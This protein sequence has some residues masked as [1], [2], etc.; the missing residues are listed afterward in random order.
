MKGTG[1][2]G[3]FFDPQ[4]SPFGY[5]ETKASDWYPM[6]V[7]EALSGGWKWSDY[8]TPAPQ[9]Q[10]IIPGSEVPDTID[11]VTDAV[12]NW[13]I[14]CDL[15]LP[16]TLRNPTS[17]ALTVERAVARFIKLIPAMTR[18]SMAATRKTYT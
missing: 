18:I 11:E 17:L 5:N 4:L 8:K 13:A 2:W 3:E 14:S 15:R 1:E 12:I 7:D 10:K 6:T 16:T 9:V